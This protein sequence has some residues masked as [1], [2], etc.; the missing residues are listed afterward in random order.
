[1]PLRVLIAEPEDF[2]PEAVD[3]LREVAEV[4]LRAVDRP[5]LE[6]AVESYDAIWLR[7]GHRV[8]ATLVARAKRC[9]IVACAVTGL[10]HIDLDACAAHGIEVLSLRG[11]VEFLREVRAT[12]EHC[13]ALSLALVRRLPRAASSVLQGAWDRDPFRGGE[14]YEKTAGIV[15]MGRLGGIVA[16]LFAAFGMEVIG[17]DPKPFDAPHVTRV[18]SLEALLRRADLVS[19]H[20]PLDASTRHLLGKKEL[21]QMKPHAVL[22]NTSRGA[23][24][25][26]AAL[27][28]ALEEGAIG[29]AALDVVEGEPHVGNGHPLVAYARD[30]DN[31]VLTPHIGGNTHESFVK[32]ETFLAKKVVAS[33]RRPGS[34]SP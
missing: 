22:V 13:L 6:A 15:G 2:T 25:D 30:H 4:D 7:L 16:E 1:M 12:A 8:D 28:A 10:D 27:L 34:D 20:V 14:L 17:Y 33:L 9:R 19:L 5:G 26:D 32:T 11:E 3:L 31:L 18:G 29:G 24:V 23:V 21:A